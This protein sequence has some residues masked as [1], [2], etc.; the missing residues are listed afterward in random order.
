MSA[1]CRGAAPTVS[2]TLEAAVRRLRAVGVPGPRRDAGL[3]LAHAIRFGQAVLLG[4]SQAVG[5]TEAIRFER[6]LRRREAR[7]PVSRILGRREFWGM[8]FELAPSTFDPRP[9]S[10]TLVST[11][12]AAFSGAPPPG[13]IL[14]LGTGSGCL[15]CA[16]LREFPAATGFGVDID[17]PA[18]RLARANA[19]RLGFGGRAR[20]LAGDWAR[21]LAND[22]FDL[23]VANPPYIARD[24]I[25]RLAPEVVRHDPRRALDGGRDG[26]DAMRALAPQLAR[27]AAPGA[28]I[29][30]E[31]GAGQ[32]DQ[33][34]LLLA[35]AG[36]SRPGRYR[37]LGGV[38]RVVATEGPT[39]GTAAV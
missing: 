29:V 1:G 24:E 39:R 34:A 12:V 10:E 16:L 19:V 23:V 30:M 33:A 26:L 31:V 6:A 11:A 38:E 28:P 4:P 3:L 27:V 15:L 9:D 35:A 36:C 2:R 20:W 25:A 37:D 21:A 5:A 8:D 13:T 7:E 14:D 22:V 18:L 32:A 17:P